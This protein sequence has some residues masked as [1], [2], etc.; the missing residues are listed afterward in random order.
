TAV[1][2]NCRPE[3]KVS[4][5]RE[6]QNYQDI[7]RQPHHCLPSTESSFP[8]TTPEATKILAP[9]FIGTCT[10][11]TPRLM[12]AS[13]VVLPLASTLVKLTT[14]PSETAFP[15]QSRTGSVS[16]KNFPAF[17]SGLIRRLQASEATCCTTRSSETLPDDAP[18]LAGPS[19]VA[20]VNRI[21]VT[22]FCAGRVCA[23]AAPCLGI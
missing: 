20:E 19:F 17:H 10:R 23:T 11:A 13:T 12:G 5:D 15:L 18:I 6:S 4:S 7:E 9:P 14:V 21:Q 22:P 16:T 1:S 3:G 8:V 2:H